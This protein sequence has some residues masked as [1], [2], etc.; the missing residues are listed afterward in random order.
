M[1]PELTQGSGTPT[2]DPK[3]VYVWSGRFSRERM[4]DNIEKLP[5]TKV[6]ERATQP[7]LQIKSQTPPNASRGLNGPNS[8]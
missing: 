6:V 2:G 4:D 7:R 3:D 8:S 5:G 1:S